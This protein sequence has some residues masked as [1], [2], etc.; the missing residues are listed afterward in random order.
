MYLPLVGHGYGLRQGDYGAGEVGR[1]TSS[2][3]ASPLR[4]RGRR[5]PGGLCW[6]R[7][8]CQ[9]NTFAKPLQRNDNSGQGSMSVGASF[10]GGPVRRAGYADPTST[11]AKSRRSAQPCSCIAVWLRRTWREAPFIRG[12]LPVSAGENICSLL[13]RFPDEESILQY[14]F[15]LQGDGEKCCKI[16][17]K[18]S[19]DVQ[20]ALEMLCDAMLRN[21]SNYFSEAKNPVRWHSF[22]PKILALHYACYEQRHR[23]GANRLASRNVEYYS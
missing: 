23:S 3:G 22:A 6:D 10:G 8:G 9:A 15:E 12:V 4:D 20:G 18:I 16:C 21:N 13:Q 1:T 19:L 2:R 7:A 5:S 17:K 14:L 11:F